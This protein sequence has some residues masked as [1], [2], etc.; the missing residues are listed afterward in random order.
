MSICGVEMREFFFEDTD[1]TWVRNIS[2]ILFYESIENED[3]TLLL[4]DLQQLI[5]VI[6]LKP[7]KFCYIQSTKK[8]LLNFSIM[9]LNNLLKLN[10]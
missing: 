4:I 5:I 2:S 7:I 1:R 8:V 3:F 9:M 10:N 6:T